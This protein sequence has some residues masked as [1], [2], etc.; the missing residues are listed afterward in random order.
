MGSR[1]AAKR[2]KAAGDRVAVRIASRAKAFEDAGGRSSVRQELRRHFKTLI[3]SERVDRKQVMQWI[4]DLEDVAFREHNTLAEYVE[5]VTTIARY[6]ADDGLALMSAYPDRERLQSLVASPEIARL[7]TLHVASTTAAAHMETSQWNDDLCKHHV[8]LAFGAEKATGSDT[9][10]SSNKRCP[11]CGEIT[12]FREI[13]V[14][15]S[16]ADDGTK[17]RFKCSTPSCKGHEFA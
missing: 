9:A 8:L 12:T 17:L 6:H 3:H 4:D 14:G 5:G 11:L 7:V 10:V 1:A 15:G 2:K 16:R 13:D